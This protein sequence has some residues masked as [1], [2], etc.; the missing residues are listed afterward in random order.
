[1]QALM[2]QLA[3]GHLDA[4]TVVIWTVIAALLAMVGGATAAVR[5]AG[6]DLGNDL[7]ALLGAMFGPVGAVPGILLALIILAF[8]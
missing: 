2:T 7:A 1:M 6:K 3:S 4:L 5:L 8:I